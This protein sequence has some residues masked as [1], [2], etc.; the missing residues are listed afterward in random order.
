MPLLLST[1]HVPVFAGEDEDLWP[2]TV[3]VYPLKQKET[4][5]TRGTTKQSNQE[6]EL[7]RYSRSSSESNTTTSCT[8]L[9]TF[10]STTLSSTFT[11]LRFSTLN[12]ATKN[13]S[14]LCTC[15]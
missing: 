10:S 13:P 9:A 11:F 12:F 4:C 14:M 3:F 7:A 5:Q 8:V 1:D 6:H 2:S 15:G